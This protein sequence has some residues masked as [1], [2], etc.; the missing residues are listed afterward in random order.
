MSTEGLRVTD[1]ADERLLEAFSTNIR[2]IVL[3]SGGE[4][5][6]QARR[7]WNA[8]ID[9]RPAVIVRCSGA[10]DVVDCVNFARD[11]GL[12]LSVRGGGHNIAGTAVCDD[13]VMIDL[14]ALRTVHVDTDRG[15]ARVAPGATWG[16]ADRETQLFGL[17]VPG[18]IVSTT[19][20]AGVTLGGGFG[21][22]TRRYGYASDNL[23]SVD[24][25][26]ADGV[27]RRASET[28]NADLFWGVRGGGGNFGV[29][30][31][32]EFR[33]RPFGPQVL[34]G[35][36]L[37]PMARAREVLEVFRR[38]TNEAPEELS[39]LLILRK[40]PPAPFVPKEAHGAPI[41]AIAACFSGSIDDGWRVI[42]PIRELDQ[43]IAD[44]F[45]PKPFRQFQQ[46]LDAGQP[47]GRRYY[48]KADYLDA[49][50]PAADEILINHAEAV[51]SPHSALLCMH[52]GGGTRRS[53]ADESSVGNRAA[54][55]V[56]NITA[57]WESSNEDALH[58][59]W[60]RN[61]WSDMRPFS[62]G[63]TY[64][65]FLT[66]DEP[67]ERVRAA[68][69]DAIYSRLAQVKAKYDPDNLFRLNQNIRPE[70]ANW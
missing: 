8:M 52:L 35:M 32:F 28:E 27:L 19:G 62:T 5:Y 10:A 69:G 16:D 60:A 66:E 3:R 46:I 37:Y 56:L 13:G 45:G 36:A 39:C 49:I 9:R 51:P 48:W 7:I 34:A 44:A 63:G 2:G 54:E 59:A 30:T 41:A 58:I 21:W 25:V 40:A 18:G 33:A 57:S 11:N 55:F 29:V 22:A 20:V 31:S 6:E 26:T 67:V 38:V 42:A 61:Y 24:I 15:V 50:P 43:P 64:V 4:D 14:S 17:I 68:Y 65:N 12:P 1:S 70:S 23:S 47:F 53:N